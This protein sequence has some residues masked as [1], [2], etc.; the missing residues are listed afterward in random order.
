MATAYYLSKNHGITN[1]VVLEKGWLGGGNTGRKTTA[2]KSNYFYPESAALFDLSIQQYEGS[3]RDLNFNVMF[4]QRGATITA[5]S[6]PDMG[7]P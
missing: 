1:I 3:S 5:H 7:K 6:E 2:I 4:S